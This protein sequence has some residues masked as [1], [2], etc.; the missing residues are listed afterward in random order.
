VTVSSYGT[1]VFDSW[2]DGK[3]AQNIT[4]VPSTDELLNAIILNSTAGASSSAGPRPGSSPAYSSAVGA[5]PV[6]IVGVKRAGWGA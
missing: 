4:V 1:Y 3:K 5:R 6:P 2:S